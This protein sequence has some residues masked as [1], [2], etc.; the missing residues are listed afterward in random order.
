MKVDK[1]PVKKKNLLIGRQDLKDR[2]IRVFQQG[3]ESPNAETRRQYN[4]ILEAFLKGISEF[5]EVGPAG[6]WKLKKRA[7]ARLKKI[8]ADRQAAARVKETRSKAAG[9]K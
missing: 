2:L 5:I 9:A 8:S 1:E 6:K 7:R 4:G 3:L